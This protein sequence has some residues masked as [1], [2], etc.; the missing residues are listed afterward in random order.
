V[1]D[2]P[3]AGSSASTSSKATS[4]P[5]A[6]ADQEAPTLERRDTDEVEWMCEIRKLF[7]TGGARDRDTAIK[8]LATSLGYA[9]VGPVISETI[10]NTLTTAVKRGVIENEGGSLKLLRRNLYEYF[11]DFLKDQF[12]AALEGNSWRERDD[13]IRGFA[14]WMGYSKTSPQIDEKARSIINGLIREGRLE[15]EGT[16]IRRR[17]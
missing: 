1:P 15:S 11:L 14:R 2:R 4:A 6:R 12:L 16:R 13:A 10:S 7:S 5:R 3:G 8:E 9:R 17:L